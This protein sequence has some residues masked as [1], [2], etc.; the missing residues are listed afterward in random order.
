MKHHFILERKERRRTRKRNRYLKEVEDSNRT[1]PG[2]GFPRVQNVRRRIN[3]SEL[4]L[5]C[6]IAPAVFA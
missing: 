4:Y 5:F 2:S 6:S 3:Q 1:A